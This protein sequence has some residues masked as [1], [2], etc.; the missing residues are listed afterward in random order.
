MEEPN[1]LKR[2]IEYF[3]NETDELVG[4]IALPAVDLAT[5]QNLL[6]VSADNPMITGFSINEKEAV[7]L[8]R[9]ADIEFDFAQYS[10]FLAA[11][12]TD[13]EATKSEGGY[14]G[15]FPSPYKLPAFPDARCVMPKTDSE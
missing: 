4:E 3:S 1:W 11:Y 8:R 14:M 5:L 6:G 7:F 15:V 2:V 13:W 12:T 10:Y 9:S